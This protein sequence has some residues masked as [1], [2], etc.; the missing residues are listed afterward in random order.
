MLMSYDEYLEK[1]GKENCVEIWIDWKVDVCGMKY[2][3]ALKVAHDPDWG[4][5][6]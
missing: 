5:E 2:T 6:A 4:F 3:E 1:T